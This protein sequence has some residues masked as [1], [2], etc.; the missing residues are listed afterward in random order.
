MPAFRCAALALLCLATLAL[1]L[2]IFAQG[3]ARNAPSTPASPLVM[4]SAAEAV[5]AQAK[6][7]ILQIRT[8]LDSAGRQ[9][10]IG[11]GFLVSADGLA[12]TNYHVISQY[13]LEPKTYRLEYAAPDGG[14][15]GMKL[16]AIDVANDLAVVKLDLAGRTDAGAMPYLE[17]DRRA[18]ADELPKGER[19][20]A[21]GN[22]LDIGFTI[23]EGTYNGLVDKSY[24]ERIHL[25]GAINAGMSGGPVTNAE[26]R[27]V[28]V[29]V[30]KRTDAEQVGFLV[31]AKFAARLIEAAKNNPPLDVA[32]TREEISRQLQTWQAA[33]YK[34]LTGQG[35]KSARYGPYLG[36]E[37]A[38]RWMNCWANTNANAVPK[39]RFLKNTTNCNSQT[40]LFISNSIYTGNVSLNFSWYQ[41]TDLNAFQFS[42]LLTQPSYGGF[43]GGWGRGGDKRLTEQQCRHDF[44]AGDEKR[45]VV[46]ATWCARAYREFEGLYDVTVIALTQDR[47]KEALQA[48][49]RMQGVSWDNANAMAKRFLDSLQLA[50][51]GGA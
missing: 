13:A 50:P 4:S 23:I 35:F 31:P 2:R 32:K 48:Q 19:I 15:G 16:L 22:P 29:N 6:P 14:K 47:G 3:N 49:L 21:M 33:F 37:S 40:G 51:P 7:R 27:I 42:R 41:A 24:D 18:I 8:L 38:A 5:Y 45:P 20:Y 34:Q 17:F 39:A 12:V 26:A 43:S 30:A 36:L 46:R 1:P 9:S 10:T 11:S 44:I 28:G 25:S